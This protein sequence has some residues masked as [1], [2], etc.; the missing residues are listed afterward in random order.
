MKEDGRI[1][2]GPGREHIGRTRGRISN[3]CVCS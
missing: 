1:I 3:G 2:R